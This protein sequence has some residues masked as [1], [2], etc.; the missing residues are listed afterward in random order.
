MEDL[1]TAPS[2]DLF[3][4]LTPERVI[5]AVEAA[6]LRCDP[7]C[8]PL[9]SFENRVYD[10]ALEGGGRVVAK[11]YRP[12]R[13][14][15]AQILE[16]HRFM[17]DLDEAEVP[18]CRHR[19]FPD[20]TSLKRTE[21]IWYCLYDRYPGRAPQELDHETAERVGMMAARIHNVGAAGDAPHRHHLNGETYV[22]G[23]LDWMLD[24]GTIPA[25][26]RDRYAAAADEIA[27]GADRLLEGVEI[28]RIHG[29]FHLGNL[30][31]R[32]GIFNVLDFDDMVLGP[33]VQDLWLVLPGRD[34]HTRRLR[35]SFLEG[36]EQFR[37]FPRAS[38]ALVEPLR[39]LRLIHYAAWLARRW[40]DPV[41]PSTW[42]HFGTEDYWSEETRE[43]E[44]IVRMIRTDDPN[45][46]PSGPEEEVL[47]NKD[48]FFD[49]EG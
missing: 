38:L 47:T 13:W 43:L 33:A 10:V 2:T 21:G 5:D 18:V 12:G 49:W 34:D 29:D 26:F 25:P 48:Y 11:F 7:A 17:E 1:G 6:G 3:L 42:P 35:E 19:S 37:P 36:Y 32:D 27:D 4:A 30:L 22:G 41:F 24:H 31:V 44:D 8:Y 39:G 15:E 45:A 9:N 14:S 46:A 20:G 23:N 40:H 28:H 16:E